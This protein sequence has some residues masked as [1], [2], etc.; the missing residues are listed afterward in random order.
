MRLSAGLLIAALSVL[1]TT[2]ATARSSCPPRKAA[3]FRVFQ[4]LLFSNPPDWQQYGIETAHVV[5]RG[6]WKDEANFRNGDPAKIRS[7]VQGLPNDGGPVVIDIENLDLHRRNKAMGSN[8]HTLARIGNWFKSASGS[9]GV[10]FYGLA[11]LGD[12]W[13]AIDVPAGGYV[14]WQHDNDAASPINARMDYIFP[15]L[16]TYYRDEQGW[17]RQAKAMICEARRISGKPVYAFIWPE[18]HPSTADA[19]REIPADF[20]QLQL[21]TVRAA[22]DGVV[23]WGGYDL[24]RDK[25]RPWDDNA[26]WWQVTRKEMDHWRQQGAKTMERSTVAMAHPKPTLND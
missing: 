18:F 8:V 21:R 5:D 9:R 13:R 25:A 12:Y 23:I 10:G 11:P 20:W 24:Q 17:V 7:V 16:Y 1:A 2:A 3:P 6:I 26:I 4:A 14:D 19:G 15:S 22:A